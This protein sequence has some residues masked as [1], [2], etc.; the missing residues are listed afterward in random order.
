MHRNS[1]KS[2]VTFTCAVF[3]YCYFFVHFIINRYCKQFET[4]SL[5]EI[6]FSVITST[7]RFSCWVLIYSYET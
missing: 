4:T 6:Y 5:D 7:F 1:C 2:Q 3:Y